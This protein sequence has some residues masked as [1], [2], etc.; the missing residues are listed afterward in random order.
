[1]ARCKFHRALGTGLVAALALTTG[2]CTPL[3]NFLASIPIFAFL[4]EAPFYDP[5]EAPR[6]PPAGAVPYS[7][8]AGELLPP[9]QPTEAG[10][11]AFAATPYGR[12]P[13][14][15]TPET[16]ERGKA[17]YD[18][19]CLVC[20][21]PAGKGDGPVVNKPGETG[22]FPF[23]PDLTLPVTV[24][25]SD[26]YLYGIIRVGRGLMPEYGSR[27]PHMDRWYVVNYVRQLQ[28]E[29]GAAVAGGQAQ[30][31]TR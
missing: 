13:V 14:T 30:G 16:L 9:I 19:Y 4:R 10:L 15:P 2:A 12:N 27:I 25:R 6:E 29:A 1:L 5:Y 18:T 11:N 3:D 20:H 21:G 7:S 22:K 26:G 24:A 28:R 17:L 23:A 31:A 8:P